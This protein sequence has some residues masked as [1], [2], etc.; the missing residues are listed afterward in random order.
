[1]TSVKL[2]FIVTKS[3]LE[4]TV[5]FLKISEKKQTEV[6]ILWSGEIRGCTVKIKTAW[7]PFQ[8]SDVGFFMIPGDELFKLNRTI[9]ESGERLVAQ[10][11]THP[12]L[13]YHSDTDSEFSVTSMEN[14]LSIVVP[15]F[16]ATSIKSY[17]ECAYYV[18]KDRKWAR[19]S[20]SDARHHIKYEE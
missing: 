10:V 6:V 2:H 12:T 19:L 15:H 3:V 1:M 16:G 7:L 9:F 8:Y 14:G 20:P 5:E 17:L 4:K 13:A 11:H 18:Y